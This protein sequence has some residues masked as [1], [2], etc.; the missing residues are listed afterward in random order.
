MSEWISFLLQYRIAKSVLLPYRRLHT[1]VKL[2][3]YNLSNC[4]AGSSAAQA[5]PYSSESHSIPTFHVLFLKMLFKLSRY[6]QIALLITTLKFTLT[7]SPKASYKWNINISRTQIL[8][9]IIVH[10]SI[11]RLSGHCFII[12][13]LPVVIILIIAQFLLSSYQ[14][15]SI[16][17]IFNVWLLKSQL[18]WSIGIMAISHVRYQTVVHA[19]FTI[20]P[21][22]KSSRVR[23]E[24]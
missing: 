19:H 18:N 20:S 12:D 13:C 23:V 22:S 7:S 24:V 11:L 21:L 8:I 5:F 6:L 4:K 14:C 17:L 15:V 9:V 16:T 3:L 1:W 2:I 10:P